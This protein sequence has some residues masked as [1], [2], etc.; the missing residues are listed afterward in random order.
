LR[1]AA[2][3]AL[4]APLLALGFR[5]AAAEVVERLRR[6]QP[7]LPHNPDDVVALEEAEAVAA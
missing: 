1:T 6:D 2:L 3:R 5:G 7:A 4:C